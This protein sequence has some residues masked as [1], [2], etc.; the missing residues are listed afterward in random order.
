[1]GRL[2]RES[3]HVFHDF[4]QAHFK[5]LRFSIVLYLI[6]LLIPWTVLSLIQETLTAF[7]LTMLVLLM[8]HAVRI[9]QL[10]RLRSRSRT[11]LQNIFLLPMGVVMALLIVFAY[12]Q[13]VASGPEVSWHCFRA[14]FLSLAL[15]ICLSAY[16]DFA[17]ADLFATVD[18]TEL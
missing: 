2:R 15:A 10:S 4:N 11:V 3:M 17:V 13:A 6:A 18:R 5:D 9:G 1:M 12:S 7:S 8:A 14:V 16:L